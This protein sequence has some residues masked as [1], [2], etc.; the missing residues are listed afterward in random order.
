[1]RNK[2]I[3][4]LTGVL[5][6]SFLFTMSACED[7]LDETESE[8]LITTDGFTSSV[9]DLERLLNGSYAAIIGQGWRWT[10][11]FALFDCGT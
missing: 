2:T 9:L 10:V 7:W 3:Q 11:C 1:M 6:L 8:P 4:F 5:L